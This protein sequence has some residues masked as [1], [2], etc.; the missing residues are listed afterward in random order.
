MLSVRIFRNSVVG[1]ECFF[2]HLSHNHLGDAKTS[3]CLQQNMKKC[4]L[5]LHEKLA[6]I[7]YSSQNT[8]LNKK[9]EILSKCWHENVFHTSTHT[10][11]LPNTSS[12]YMYIYKKKTKKKNL[13]HRKYHFF[14]PQPSQPPHNICTIFSINPH[15][16]IH[17]PP[18]SV[19]LTFY[20]H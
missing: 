19:I 2:K 1:H 17:T 18:L 14:L 3:T 13:K 15:T 6:I 12:I 5:C 11:N 7:T 4:P 10:H 16:L 9:S 20:E 8:L